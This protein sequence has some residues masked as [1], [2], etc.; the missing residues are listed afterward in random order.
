MWR[1][2]RGR[3][4]CCCWTSPPTIKKL[5]LQIRSNLNHIS[6]FSKLN[7]FVFL[8]FS[9]SLIFIKT[10][11]KKFCN[12]CGWIQNPD[13]TKIPDPVFV[14]RNS[15]QDTN[16]Q[17]ICTWINQ[18]SNSSIQLALF[19]S[20]SGRLC[21]SWAQSFQFLQQITIKIFSSLLKD[22]FS[23]AAQNF[24][25]NLLVISTSLVFELALSR[26]NAYWQHW[27]RAGPRQTC[28]RYTKSSVERTR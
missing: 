3:C 22:D 27:R 7:V 10:N 13:E 1:L 2:R 28:W 19:L 20:L 23:T 4:I 26:Y 25:K 8:L 21:T 16:I 14:F 12:Q 17:Q 18:S 24:L 11:D 6:K 5:F 15:V 9:R